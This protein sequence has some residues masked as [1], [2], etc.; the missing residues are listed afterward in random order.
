MSV[1]IHHVPGRLRLQIGRLKRDP[2]AAASARRRIAT[3]SGVREA[4]VNLL[5]GSLIIAYDRGGTS[6]ARLWRVL[7]AEG[8]VAGEPP[9][10][11]RERAVRM[12]LANPYVAGPGD[13][14]VETLC[15]ML[16]DKLLERSALALVGALI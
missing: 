14:L 8:L 5:T 2:A 10:F 12:T 7:A 13:R 3:E 16:L 11:D 1:Y 15:G 6:P 4:K 9:R